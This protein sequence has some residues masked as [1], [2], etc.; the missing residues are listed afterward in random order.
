MN[1]ADLRSRLQVSERQMAVATAVLMGVLVY[2]ISFTNA[3]F[4][5]QK[6]LALGWGCAAAIY[7]IARSGIAARQGWRLILIFLSAFLALRYMYW[8]TVE[9][10]IYTGAYDFIGMSLLYL[11]EMYG[12]VVY[13][14]GLFVNVWPLESKMVA[15]PEDADLW[16]TVDVLI[17]T[18]NESEDIVRITVTAA[19]QI[20]YP[21][22]KLRVFLLDD[23]ATHVKRNDPRTGVLAWERHYNLRRL[24]ENLGAG[25]I[26]RE[27][28]LQAKA[29]NINHALALTDGALV[30]MLDCDHVP[31][32]DILKNTLGHFV[33]DPKLFLVQT[34]HFFINPAPIEKSLAGVGDPSTESDLFYRRIHTALDF[35]NA[36]YFCG[37][38]AVLRRKF[39]MEVGGICGATI[40]E[41]AETA[42]HLHSRGYNSVY[43]NK[44]MICGLSPESYDD[45]VSQH[46]RWAQGMVQLLL[47][48]NPLRVKGLSVSQRIAYFNSSIF[49]LFSIPR[50]IYF[51]SPAAYLILNMSVYHASWIQILA[52]TAP[53]IVTLHVMMDHFYRGTRQPLFSEIYETVQSLF[54]IP[55]VIAVLLNPWN[56]SFHV[57]PKGKLN[58]REYLSPISAP[59][60]LIIAINLVAM[61]AA[62]TKWNSNPAIRDVIIVTGVWCA[63]NVFMVTLALGAFW[64]RKQ[65]RKFYRIGSTGAVKVHF[66]RLGE[67]LLGEVRD[68]SLTGIAFAVVAPFVPRDQDRIWLEV[69]DSYGRCYRFESQIKRC[70]VA[71]DTYFCGSEFVMD[72]VSYQEV[73]AYVFG[74]SQRWVDVWN[75]KSAAKGTYHMLWHFFKMGFHAVR[76][77]ALALAV[78]AL[79]NLGRLVVRCFTTAIVKEKLTM[80]G[81][82]AVY[83]FYLGLAFVL[84]KLDKKQSRKLQRSQATGM[85]E[86]YF[87]RT[88]AIVFGKL[89]DVSLTG[90]GV[91]AEL[92]FQLDPG[93]RVFVK[94]TGKDGQD[95]RFDCMIQRVIQKDGKLLCGA[96]FMSDIFVY[97]NIVRFVH[98]D[99][100][101]M[102]RSTSLIGND[103][104][105][106][107]RSATIGLLLQIRNTVSPLL[108]LVFLHPEYR[109]NTPEEK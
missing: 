34:P 12:F 61:V 46:S 40:T 25:Y 70:V 4:E 95:Y 51:I 75:R 1:L 6:Q 72:Q 88:N 63:F 92:P 68:I 105:T 2:S 82:W 59:F 39:L 35:W 41:D 9:S 7:V 81:C 77:S 5:N 55:A 56:P 104:V 45:Y 28:N 100:I 106:K 60:F 14:L 24:A 58:S 18:Y 29:G 97:P 8:R 94:A 107:S 26:T 54:L 49:W 99:A 69:S 17:P 53:Y 10:L 108:A 47:L 109:V 38:A 65:I 50:F 66:S 78:D 22:D 96:E 30:L 91:L 16:P 19:M 85:A 33:A 27:T 73:V 57:T 76:T 103:L 93:E 36:S 79:R 83:S 98:G 48:N 90:M 13:L 20:D 15:L 23:G 52:F 102:I 80:I 43:I 64:E 71:N 44:P 32:S 37:S 31:T 74:D 89:N 101:Q 67:T 62:V 86:I 21:K 42:F 87:P 11:A 84:E 3:Y